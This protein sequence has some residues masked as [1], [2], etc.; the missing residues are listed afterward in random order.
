MENN[1]KDLKE[2]QD[3]S[4]DSEL[5]DKEKI[6]KIKAKKKRKPVNFKKIGLIVAVVMMLG[7]LLMNAWTSTVPTD[8][9]IT[10]QGVYEMNEKG[11]IK[12]VIITKTADT[13]KITDTAGVTY[14]CVNPKY[15]EFIYDLI[16]AGIPIK[17]QQSSLYDALMSMALTIPTTV[18]LLMIIYYLSSTI[19]GGSTKMF[20][21]LDKKQNNV[22]FDDIAG[23]SEIKEEVAEITS[24]LSNYK[25]LAANGAR[26]CKGLLLYGPPGVGKTL[27]A[28]AIANETHLPFISASGSDFVEMFVGVGA[29]RVRSLWDLALQN[30]PCIL[31]LDEIDSLGKR[32]SGNAS[33][34]EK[35]QTLNALLQRMDGLNPGSGVFVIAA[36]NRKEDMDEAL[37]RPGRF[38]RHIYIG[39]PRLKKDKE[40][41]VEL[42]LKT[43][44]KTEDVTVEKVASLMSNMSGAQIEDALNNAVYSSFKNGRD[45]I[46]D[47]SD[48]D[49]GIMSIY[50]DGVQVPVSSLHDRKVTAVHEAGHTIMNLLIGRTVAKVSV[51]PYSSGIGGM[52]VTTD[53]NDEDKRLRFESDF[54]NDIK[55]LLAGKAAEEIMFNESTQGASNDLERATDLAFNLISTF[56]YYDNL[57]SFTAINKYEAI[58]SISKHNYD[59]T[60]QVLK[61]TFELV[62][63]ELSKKENLVL[64]RKLSS[65]LMKEKTII[66]PT[67]EM[68]S[69]FEENLEI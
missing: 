47:L 36:T 66:Y 59:K 2:A 62:K 69:T 48:I 29:A 68:I 45:G 41:L 28:K 6:K 21:L 63:N 30:A 33:D 46:I 18:L 27:I 14:S 15:D 4:D 31:F 7:M 1:E 57:V 22:K 39:K 23:I 54:I 34:S 55:T 56:G 37:L 49:N 13:F 8:A 10:L 42:Y 50:T 65:Q 17:V 60:N 24:M 35:N 20:T 3:L 40:E 32:R 51:V 9:N 58:P 52:T 53:D 67:I 19:V 44:R 38:D 26:P 11:L 43:K 64:L 16:Q 12:E 5:S 25:K 61:D